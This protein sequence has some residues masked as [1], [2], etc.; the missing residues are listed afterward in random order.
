VCRP[1]QP[2]GA[3][4]ARASGVPWMYRCRP[5]V[6]SRVPPFA[7]GTRPVLSGSRSAVAPVT[8]GTPVS[9][10]PGGLSVLLTHLG[11]YEA[12]SAKTS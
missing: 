2:D 6:M 10:N 8:A 4:H 12:R 11:R 7:A 1:S 9:S 3:H 5:A